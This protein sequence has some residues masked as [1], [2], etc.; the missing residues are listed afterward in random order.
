MLFRSCCRLHH[1]NVLWLCILEAL[2]VFKSLQFLHT[3]CSPLLV[4]S[5]E[6]FAELMSS[7]AAALTQR[8]GSVADKGE[9]I[10]IWHWVG[11]MTMDVIGTAAFG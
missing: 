3:R 11:D 4:G 6:G 9:I 10:D 8:L 5:L 2:P 7:S 1:Q